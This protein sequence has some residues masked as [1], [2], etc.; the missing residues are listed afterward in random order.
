MDLKLRTEII[1]VPVSEIKPYHQNA[2]SHPEDQIV[3]LME[4]FKVAGMDQPIVLESDN[5]IIK[6]HGR[7]EA[8]RRLG[9]EKVPCI[10][11]D[12][13][14]DVARAIRLADNET[15]KSD[16]IDEILK[17]ELLEIRNLNIPMEYTGFD[18]TEVDSFLRGLELNESGE[19]VEK[20]NSNED[21]VPP[22]PQVPKVRMGDL[23]LL[24]NHRLLCGDSTDPKQVSRL[25]NYYKCDCGEIHA[26]EQ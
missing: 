21:E 10:I 18:L 13:S 9:M 2:K 16:Y 23:F 19:V 3:K 14:K 26:L 4:Q 7:F 20:D 1:L 25:M 24:G 17:K 11:S 6:G 22:A 8:A 12:V 15:A 5:T